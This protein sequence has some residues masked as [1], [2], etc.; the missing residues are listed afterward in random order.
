MGERFARRLASEVREWVSE[1]LVT[2]EQA[3]RILARYPEGAGWL[4]RP[5]ALFALVGG[6]LIAAGVALV[7]AHNWENIH[8][9]VKLVGLVVLMGLAHGAG[10]AARGRGYPRVGAGV[11]VIGGALLLVGIALVGQIY[12]LS[13]RPSDAV[14]MWW[15]LLLPAGYAL[16]TVALAGLAYAGVVVWFL[17]AL[18]DPATW[19][20]AGLHARFEQATVALG[21]FGV[22]LFGVGALHAGDAWRRLRTQL[23]SL[24]LVG[25]FAALLMLGALW[26][27]GRLRPEPGAAPAAMILLLLAAAAAVASAAGLPATRPGLRRGFVAL[28][29]GLLAYL[30]A[31]KTAVAT[32]HPAIVATLALVG[33]GVLL[34]AALGVILFGARWGRRAW[35]NVG[36]LAIGV[37]AIVR[38]V[39]LFGTMLEAGA[40]FLST[41]VF[42]LAL[43]WALERVRRRMTP[44]AA[45]R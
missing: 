44:S 16:P 15:V 2:A 18:W 40:L 8:R 39:D 5:A 11:T 23:E 26:R 29:L 31:V 41:G 20:G 4:A 32:G 37:E 19:L 21:A 43:G 12:N 3:A 35:V 17:M 1:G 6:A 24:G 9:W 45:E 27:E 22:V 14:L 36:L 38:Y 34:G 30:G 10:L 42:V 25:L 13:G 28:L 33:W 7:V